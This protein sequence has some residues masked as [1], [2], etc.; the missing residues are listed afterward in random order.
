MAAEGL[1]QLRVRPNPFAPPQGQCLC[2]AAHNPP[3]VFDRSIITQN[4][5]T[6]KETNKK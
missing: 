1:R 2:I 6:K 3:P 4:R 5:S